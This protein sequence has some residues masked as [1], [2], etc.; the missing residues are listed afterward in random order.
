MTP[1][2]VVTKGNMFP[3]NTHVCLVI[4]SAV[5]YLYMLYLRE[6][7]FFVTQLFD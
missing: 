7:V 1:T 6:S 5:L 4:I 2:K 3:I